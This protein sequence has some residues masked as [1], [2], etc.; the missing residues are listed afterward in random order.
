M[1]NTF[2]H[3]VEMHGEDIFCAMA[4]KRAVEKYFKAIEAPPDV[5]NRL[6]SRFE[7]KIMGKYDMSHYSE[8]E[9]KWAALLRNEKRFRN[10][11]AFIWDRLE[12]ALD[13]YFN[14]YDNFELPVALGARH[15]SDA[16]RVVVK[17]TRAFARMLGDEQ[18]SAYIKKYWTGNL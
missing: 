11:R 16:V 13:E 7:S 5:T 1:S 12:E 4:L 17:A 14:D 10:D 3:F 6:N 18:T 9:D 8:D 15:S 2:T